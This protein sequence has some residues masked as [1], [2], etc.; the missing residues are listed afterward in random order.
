MNE[1]DVWHGARHTSSYLATNIKYDALGGKF[2]IKTKVLRMHWF[3]QRDNN[4]NFPSRYL[5]CVLFFMLMWHIIERKYFLFLS[6]YLILPSTYFWDSFH[7][8]ILQI[9]SKTYDSKFKTKTS[10]FNVRKS[11]NLKKKQRKKETPAKV[12]YYHP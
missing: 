11:A 2:T 8:F 6:F 5:S 9:I 1:A 12:L 3:T 4:V 10:T 7:I